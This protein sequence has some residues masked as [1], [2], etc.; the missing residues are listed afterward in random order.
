MHIHILG[1][2][3]TFM[4]GLAQI[5]YKLGHKVTGSDEN[6]YPPMSDQLD[7]QGIKVSTGYSKKYLQTSKPD[8]V[9]VGNGLSRGNPALEY[10]LDQSLPFTSGPKWLYQ[11]V[12]KNKHVLAV[13]GTHGKT[14]TT[15]ILAWILEYAGKKPDF[16]VGGIAENFKLSARYNNSDYF[17]IEADEYDTAVFDKRAKFIHYYPKTLIINNIEFDHADIFRDISDIRI[18]FHHLLKTLSSETKIIYP[19]QDKEIQQVLAMG[20][21]SKKISFLGESSWKISKADADHKNFLLT[22]KN[23]EVAKVSWSLFGKHNA[24]NALSAIIAANQI[25]VSVKTACE[26]LSTFKSV[27]RR[28]ECIMNFNDIRVYDD[29]AHHPTAIHKTLRALRKHAGNRRIIAI[30]EPRSNTMKMG[31]HS[32]ILAKAFYYADLVLIF[33]PNDLSWDI[34]SCMRGLKEKCQIFAKVEDIIIDIKKKS[35]RGDSIVIMS[36]GDFEN[37]QQRLVKILS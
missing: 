23:N 27:K 37:I 34:L 22:Y 21:W 12:L 26:A 8:L 16:L 6:I 5:A 14:T 17:V 28:L 10:L 20:C 25:G 24:N 4:G 19:E 31:I 32:N 3:G 33:K 9:L 35:R 2:G 13:S 15:A 30:M 18:Q 29:F 11:E 36:N 7:A 1:V